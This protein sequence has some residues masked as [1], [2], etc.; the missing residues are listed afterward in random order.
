MTD[1]AAQWKQD[2][3][4]ATRLAE[5]FG[6]DNPADDPPKT[7][8]LK[9]EQ[10]NDIEVNARDFA[11]IR[12]WLPTLEYTI[13]YG[14]EEPV[15]Y[16]ELEDGRRIEV[17]TIEKL[18]RSPHSTLD[19]IAIEIGDAPAIAPKNWHPIFRAL[20]AIRK[21]EDTGTTPGQETRGW[22]AGFLSESLTSGEIDLDTEAGKT[23]AATGSHEAF[24]DKDDHLYIRAE[25][26]DKYIRTV[27][28]V[29]RGD[30][31]KTALCARLRGLGF[32]YANVYPAR[33]KH[34]QRPERRYWQS[35]ARFN[36][37]ADQ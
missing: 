28:R 19:A 9:D 6:P 34:R 24:C 5:E 14:L 7:I 1:A 26:L 33:D 16:L 10:G 23:D 27:L 29:S 12:L 18:R 37:K 15:F 35:P 11:R 25:G 2:D 32:E 8:T 17:G 30:I 3:A 4:E 31:S 20:L 22:I 21:I 36:P 13:Q